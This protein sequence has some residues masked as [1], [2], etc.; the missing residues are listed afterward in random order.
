MCVERRLSSVGW[1][2]MFVSL[3]T[4]V[5]HFVCSHNIGIAP[6]D[7]RFS[8]NGLP[9]DTDEHIRFVELSPDVSE[10][11]MPFANERSAHLLL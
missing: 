2:V 5:S 10:F 9:S 1:L 4:V 3:S 7:M 8:I 6:D 11:A